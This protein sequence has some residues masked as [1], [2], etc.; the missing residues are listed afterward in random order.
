MARMLVRSLDGFGAGQEPALWNFPDSSARVSYLAPKTPN[1]TLS[2][3]Y[4]AEAARDQQDL[5]VLLRTRRSGTNG[6]RVC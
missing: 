1:R 3:G 6:R 5:E 2:R 4:Q